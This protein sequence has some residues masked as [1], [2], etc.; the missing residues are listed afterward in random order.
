MLEFIEKNWLIIY[1]LFQIAFFILVWAMKKTYASK[2]TV[3]MLDK[4]VDQL[5]TEVKQL[6]DKD[7]HHALALKV[8]TVDGK[9]DGVSLQLSKLQNT[10]NLLLENELGDK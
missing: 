9:I 8:N 5:E 7:D 4:R 3:E 2:E 6:P 1:S 10:T